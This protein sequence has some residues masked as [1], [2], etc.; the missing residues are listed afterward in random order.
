MDANQGRTPKE[1]HRL[2]GGVEDRAVGFSLLEQ[3]IR[4]DDLAGFLADAADVIN[5]KL[6]KSG[7]LAAAEIVAIV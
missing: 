5:V 3:S 6:G 7:P 4:K 1:T 2:F